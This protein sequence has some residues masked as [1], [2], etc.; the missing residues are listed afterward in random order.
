MRMAPASFGWLSLTAIAK[1]PPPATMSRAMSFWHPMA[2][3]VINVLSSSICFSR[4]GMAVISL[5]LSSTATWPN[6]IPCSLAHA[7]TMCSG[8][9]PWAAS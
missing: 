3:I 6:A 4:R 7:L 2:S 9:S 1:S 5:D 8:P